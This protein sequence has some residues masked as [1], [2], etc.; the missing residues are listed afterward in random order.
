MYKAL[1]VDDEIEAVESV[2]SAFDWNSLHVRDIVKISDPHGLVDRI[3]QENPHIVFIDIEMGI[4][5]GL[6]VIEE[7]RRLLPKTLFVIISGHNNFEYA[8]VSI[9]LDVVYYLLKPFTEY[10]VDVTTEKLMNELNVRFGDATGVQ[11]ND[12]NSFLSSR[13]QFQDFMLESGITFPGRYRFV[14]SCMEKASLESLNLC[15]QEKLVKRYK[16][17][18]KKY[19]LVVKEPLSENSMILLENLSSFSNMALGISDV[20]SAAEE[21]Y[22]G[23]K[24]ANMLAYGTFINGCFGVYKIEEGVEKDFDSLMNTMEQSFEREDFEALYNLLKSLPERA[25]QKNYTMEQ[26]VFFHNAFVIRL[27]SLLRQKGKKD[28]LYILSFEEL[29]N[30]YPDVLNMCH[31]LNEALGAILENQD[32]FVSEKAKVNSAEIVQQVKEYLE[33]NY[34]QK[35]RIKE[36]GSMFY[37]SEAYLSDIFKTLTHKTIIEYLADIRI[38]TAKELLRS[39]R[40]NISN[41]AESVGYGDYCYFNKI[42]K[43]YV[44]VTPYQYRKKHVGDVEYE[45]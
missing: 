10:E 31:A 11:L 44:G 26:V 15:L 27:N 36:L 42:F 17:G 34:V 24:Q 8:R 40:L 38:E 6:Q 35:I 18:S 9:R 1:I 33:K 16:I 29:L 23:F 14:V 28:F 32:E 13:Q 21:I 19:L 39:T 41:I 25:V 30:E 45:D 3:V 12:I 22:S 7:C 37:I 2:Y 20:V 43:K 5:S 4:V